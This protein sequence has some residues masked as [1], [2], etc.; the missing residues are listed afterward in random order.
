MTEPELR[1]LVREAIARQTGRPLPDHRPV[2]TLRQH[3][4]H[5]LFAVP[6]GGDTGGPCVIEPAVPCTHCGYCKSY[7]H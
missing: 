1:A 6:A 3:P 7:G 5:E 2:V 4:S